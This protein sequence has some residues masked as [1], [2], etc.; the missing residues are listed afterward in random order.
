MLNQAIDHATQ[1]F[2][3]HDGILK[4][5]QTLA[6]GIAPRTLYAMRDSGLLRQISR[7]TFQ[8]ADHEPLGNPD[9]VSVAKR[10]QKAIVC[11]ISALHFYGLT[12]QIPHKVHIALPQS[13]EKPRLDFPPLDIIWLSEKSYSAEITEQT[14]VGIPIKVYSIEKTIADCFKF[15]NKIG[16]DVALEALKEYLKMPRRNIESLLTSA[17]VGPGREFAHPLPGS[18]AMTGL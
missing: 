10:I 3:A 17:R 16:N 18:P 9:L 4:T 13:A 8:L 1:I 2:S 6:L 7:G 12:S 11:L 14:I 15:R 5:S